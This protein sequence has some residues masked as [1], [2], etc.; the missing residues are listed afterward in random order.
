VETYTIKRDQQMKTNRFNFSFLVLVIVSVCLFSQCK[1]DKI[2]DNQPAFK[3][4]ANNYVDPQA[5]SEI[6]KTCTSYWDLSKM[7][8]STLVILSYKDGYEVHCN[9]L[10][11]EQVYSFVIKTDTAGKWISDSK[12]VLTTPRKNYFD[13]QKLDQLKLA[14]IRN[15]W[16]EGSSLDTSSFHYYRYD[17]GFLNTLEVHNKKHSRIDVSVFQ[18]KIDC[19]RAMENRRNNV[20]AVFHIGS[21]NIIKGHWW[22]TEGW[23]G[24]VVVNQLNTLVEVEIFSDYETVKDSL[25]QTAKEIARRI[26]VLSE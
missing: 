22:F 25:F 15:F 12:I 1:K 4:P 8:D 23:N 11:E 3:F 5:Y 10:S 2:S 21:Q 18:L 7:T 17:I 6:Q 20:A 26:D 13:P 14:N 9:G 24:L 19:V 16:D